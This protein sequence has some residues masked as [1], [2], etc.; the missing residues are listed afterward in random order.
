MAELLSNEQ[1]SADNEVDANISPDVAG[2]PPLAADIVMPSDAPA[3]GEEATSEAFLD[4]S[5]DPAAEEV[6]SEFLDCEDIDPKDLPLVFAYEVG[7]EESKR[8]A[9]RRQKE[10]YEN[11]IGT[12]DA[13]A[14]RKLKKAPAERKL[15]KAPPA[16]AKK[17]PPSAAKPAKKPLKV[18]PTKTGKQPTS[19]TK[20]PN[21]KYPIKE[22][23]P[24]DFLAGLGWTRETHN[25]KTDP[26]HFDKYWFP[27]KTGCKLRSIPEC[28]RFLQLLKEDKGDETKAFD[29]LKKR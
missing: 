29:R 9:L 7:N 28:K 12:E 26:H 1:P 20:A 4:C 8:E 23:A 6:S 15:K 24:E 27:P 5:D 2:E 18:A 21:G 14:E 19:A 17:A 22:P 25:R 13:P 16:A 11:I 10:Y 3:A